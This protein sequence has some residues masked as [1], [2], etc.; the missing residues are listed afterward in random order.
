MVCV[1]PALNPIPGPGGG[2][3][4]LVPGSYPCNTIAWGG[5]DDIAKLVGMGSLPLMSLLYKAPLLIIC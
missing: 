1:I 5:I 2:V 4:L 3:A